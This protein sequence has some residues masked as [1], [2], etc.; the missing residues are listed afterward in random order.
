MKA[1]PRLPLITLVALV[2]AGCSGPAADEDAASPSAASVDPEL[3]RGQNLYYANCVACHLPA[4]TGL[5]GAFPPLAGSDFLEGG[6]ERVIA[7]VLY[8]NQGPI[9]VNGVE[10]NGV[11]PRFAHLTDEE[12]AAVVTYILRSW[13]N[14]YPAVK[15]ADVAAVRAPA[16]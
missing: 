9:T 11:M 16:Q 13:G 7:T 5:E 14:D 2:L 6:P 8:S 3:A 12:V 4:G 10:Y 1:V 15:P